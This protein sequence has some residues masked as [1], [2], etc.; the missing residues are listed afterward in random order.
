MYD[1]DFIK[2]WFDHLVASLPSVSLVDIHTHLGFNDPDGFTFSAGQLIETLEAA[3][4]MG[5]AMPMH[6]PA[7][8]PPANDAVLAQCLASGSRIVAFCRLDPKVEPVAE[9][10]RCLSKGAAGIKLHP[11][12][13]RFELSDPEVE[14]IFQ[15]AH[16]RRLPVLIHAGRGIPTLGRDAV[17]LAERYR[18][19]RIILAH[20]AI[21][22]LNWIWREARRH[23]NLFF[24]TAWWHPTD[25][26]ALF[27]LVPPGQLLY[28]SDLPYFTP[29]MSSVMSARFALQAG[30]N[31]EQVASVLGGQARRLLAGEDPLDLGP[32]PGAGGFAQ[33]IML[34]R[35][36]SVLVLAVG[37]MLMGRTGYEPLALA[38]LACDIGDPTSPEADVCTNVLELLN[39][40]Q[41]FVA[42]H[43]DDGPPLAAGIRLIMLAACISRTPDVA[44]PLLH[45]FASEDEIR[46]QTMV[47][48]R[49]LSSP[50]ARSSNTTAVDL[51]G[52]SAADHLVI[53]TV[54]D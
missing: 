32:A 23:P 53:E 49:L 30:L 40:Q 26:A 13:E 28:G 9:A 42:Q 22:D 8:Y 37:R 20:A 36:T 6:E 2:P 38:R 18:G 39:R 34:E 3:D 21:C 45:R 54:P 16:E 46:Q 43:P 41:Q 33:S 48:H 10:E 12:A 4:A 11:R 15:L 44:L 27:A 7:G 24:D 52:S 47:A 19:A 1:D 5:V 17:A 51:R 25:L 31:L 14:P 35:M 50:Q 29:Y